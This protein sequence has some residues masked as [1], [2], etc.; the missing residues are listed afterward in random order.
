MVTRLKWSYSASAVQ[1]VA[2]RR[3]AERA[4]WRSY[5]GIGPTG[6]AIADMMM[7]CACWLAYLLRLRRVSPCPFARTKRRASA[8]AEQAAPSPSSLAAAKTLSP[9]SS[10][11]RHDLLLLVTVSAQS[12]DLR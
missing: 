5:A 8:V 2:D 6:Q 7:P 12:V 3:L 9:A 10:K 4:K 11:L 1:V